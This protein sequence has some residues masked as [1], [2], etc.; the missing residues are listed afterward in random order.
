MELFLRFVDESFF[1]FASTEEKQ[2]K[3]NEIGRRETICLQHL[4]TTMP[5][6]LSNSVLHAI[7]MNR[8]KLNLLC[9]FSAKRISTLLL[10]N[11]ENNKFKLFVPLAPATVVCALF[12]FLTRQKPPATSFRERVNIFEARAKCARLLSKCRRGLW[13]NKS[14]TLRFFYCFYSKEQ[15]NQKPFARHSVHGPT[16]IRK[17]LSRLR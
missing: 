11:F 3:R 13:S 7:L 16:S 10:T 1:G 4:C 8:P 9:E 14:S 17:I 6:R 12:L 2:K 15:E 5:A